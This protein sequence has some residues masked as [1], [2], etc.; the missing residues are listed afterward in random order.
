M[1]SLFGGSHC[2]CAPF[3]GSHCVHH[4]EA[5]TVRTVWRLSLC[6]PF[7]GSHCAHRLEALTVRTVW[8]LSLCAPF[9][10]SHCAHRLEALTVRTVWRLSLCAPFGGSHCA[11]LSLCALFHILAAGIMWATASTWSAQKVGVSNWKRVQL[12]S[13]QAPRN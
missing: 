8:R 12:V 11:Q 13:T 1:R 2:M 7:G 10:G 6:A 9:G 4:L 3:G 5:L